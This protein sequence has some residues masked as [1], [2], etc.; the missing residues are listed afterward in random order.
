MVSYWTLEVSYFPSKPFFAVRNL[1]KVPHEMVLPLGKTQN[2][3]KVLSNFLSFFWNFGHI[4]M[5]LQI[6]RTF[7]GGSANLLFFQSTRPVRQIF[8][9]ILSIFINLHNLKFKPGV[10]VWQYMSFNT[11]STK[12]VSTN[13]L[14]L[15]INV[16]SFNDCIYLFDGRFFKLHTLHINILSS[17]NFHKVN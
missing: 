15:Y 9:H 10:V 3:Q 13:L 5:L 14:K 17:L 8:I 2:L 6:C 11:S 12:N 16:K 1:K 4:W 7:L